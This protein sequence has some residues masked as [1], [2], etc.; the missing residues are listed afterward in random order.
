MNNDRIDTSC[1]VIF[2]VVNDKNIGQFK[3]NSNILVSFSIML[4]AIA[5]N[6]KNNQEML[7]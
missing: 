4:P 3:V 5:V 2:T 7:R 1:S 6:D